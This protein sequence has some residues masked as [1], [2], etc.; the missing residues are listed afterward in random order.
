MICEVRLKGKHIAAIGLTWLL[1][2]W[3]VAKS[4]AD[5]IGQ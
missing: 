1:W 3:W 2:A 5:S 4:V